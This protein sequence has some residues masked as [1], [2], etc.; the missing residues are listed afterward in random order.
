MTPRE[1]ST[2]AVTAKLAQIEQG[3]VLR[4]MRLVPAVIVL[5]ALAGGCTPPSEGPTSS[6]VSVVEEARA[7][8]ASEAQLAVLETGK[9]SFA[10]Y[11]Q[12]VNLTID[13]MRSHGI[14]VLEDQPSDKSG[15][16]IIS[17]SWSPTA[18]GGGQ[19]LQALGDQCLAENSQFVEQ[20]Y[21]LQPSS[22][23]AREA[24]YRAK[25][26]VIVD[27]L[28]TNGGTVADDAESDAARQVSWEVLDK[29]GVDCFQQAGLS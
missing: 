12:A 11:Q 18:G 2:D 20:L 16:M 28:R 1:L 23:E 19:D 24:A 15:V 29:S 5:V 8:G 26:A 21:Q 25:R 4:C 27:C 7:A 14:E 22:V 10:Q 17:Y 6:A 9:V 13:C 3:G